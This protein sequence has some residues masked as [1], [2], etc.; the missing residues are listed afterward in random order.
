MTENDKPIEELNQSHQKPKEEVS[1]GLAGTE[2][3]KDE[4]SD[5]DGP[6]EDLADQNPDSEVNSK[7]TP[8]LQPS[9]ETS[10]TISD[11][12]PEAEPAPQSEEENKPAASIEPVAEPS[13]KAEEENKPAPASEPEAE[14]APKVEEETQGASASEPEA[15]PAH[16]AVEETEGAPVS[17]PETASAPAE[18]SETEP[19]S[20]VAEDKDVPASKS[21]TDS[22]IAAAPDE[23]EDSDGSTNEDLPPLG[24]DYS[25]FSKELLVESLQKLLDRRPIQEIRSEVESIK[26][27]FY[28]RHH[29]KLEEKKAAFLASGGN[30]EEFALPPDPL[31]EQYKELYSSYRQRK[32]EYNKVLE[33][34][35]VDNLEKKKEIIESIKNLIHSQE[36]LNKTFNDFRDLQNDW[37]TVGPVP[38]SELASLWENYH[39]HVENFYDFIK[40]NK[41]LRDLDLKKNLEAKIVLCEKAEGL[42]LEPN[43]L[44]AFKTLQEYHSRWREIGPVPREK[45]D[46]IWDRFKESTALINKKHQDHFKGLKDEQKDNLEAKTR[47]CEQVDELVNRNVRSPKE[48]NVLSQ[49]VIELQKMWRTIGFAPKK[50]N[51]QIYERFRNACDEFFNKKREFFSAHREVQNQNLQLKTE[52]CI[53]AEALAKSTDWKETTDELIQI[54][55]KWKQIGPLPKKHSDALWLRFRT[56]CDTFFENKK[57][58]FQG[59]DN[60]QESN[61]VKKKELIEK[62]K[63]YKLGSDNKVDLENL[64]NFQSQFTDIGYIPIDKKDTIQKDFRDAINKLF[65]KLNIDDSN[66]ESLKFRQKID[67]LAQSPNNRSRVRAE[68]EKLVNK[69]KQLESDIILWENNIGFFAKSKNSDAMIANVRKKIEQGKEQIETLKEKINIIDQSDN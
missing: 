59:K 53:Q 23:D 2:K 4:S 31:E 20:R 66:R 44:S 9:I 26:S 19:A 41:E 47:L 28:K 56:A 55:K 43:I 17:E 60:E 22:S 24:V 3:T 49:K 46:E 27:A 16:K 48:W 6:A 40:I 8:D 15:K 12:E 61:L 51:N 58:H 35:K 63:A 14:P 65:D 30:E 7:D 5:K 42:L 69:L 29:A 32:I 57:N 36:S 10:A 54:Q 68:R 67:I 18:D 34:Q 64:K 50:E 1:D 52:L 39:H 13:A 21:E 45:K 62:V 11:S 38:Q 37:R 33:L 25:E